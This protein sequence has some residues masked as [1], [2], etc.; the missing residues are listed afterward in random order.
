MISRRFIV[1]GRGRFE[2]RLGGD[3]GC[4]RGGSGIDSVSTCVRLES[5]M[6]ERI[7][8]LGVAL[9]ERAPSEAMSHHRLK[10]A[11]GLWWRCNRQLSSRCLPLKQR[12]RHLQATAVS[13]DVGSAAQDNIP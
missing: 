4:I 8:C 9:G 13:T 5:R 2:G 12:A 3:P 7:V 1:R 10:E 11:A 6:R